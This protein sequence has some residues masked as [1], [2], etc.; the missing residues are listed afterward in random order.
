MPQPGPAA[1]SAAAR[2][3][4]VRTIRP[5]PERNREPARQAALPRP[6]WPLRPRA[7][8]WPAVALT[9]TRCGSQGAEDLA[10][11]LSCGCNIVRLRRRC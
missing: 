10:F 6:H 1:P 9:M 3:D 5:N 2:Q 7:A 11:A 4:R 8:R